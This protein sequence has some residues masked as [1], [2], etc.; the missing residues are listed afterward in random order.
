MYDA[1]IM[2]TGFPK[3][4]QVADPYHP[5]T[6]LEIDTGCPTGTRKTYK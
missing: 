3:P 4:Q 5:L 2:P 6:T 1:T